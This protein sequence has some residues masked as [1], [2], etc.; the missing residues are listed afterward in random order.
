M[1]LTC[2]LCGGVFGGTYDQQ[3][4]TTRADGKYCGG[5]G[6]TTQA[7]VVGQLSS[8]R[9][10]DGYVRQTTIYECGECLALVREDSLDRHFRTHEDW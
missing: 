2:S 4:H 9:D 3:L 5:I 10:H 6:N 1:Q 7:V 8:E